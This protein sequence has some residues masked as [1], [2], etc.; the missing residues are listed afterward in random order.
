MLTS[1]SR[2]ISVICHDLDIFYRVRDISLNGLRGNLLSFK[3]GSGPVGSRTVVFS[4]VV[5]LW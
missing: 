4:L 5:D 3:S 1:I 2:D